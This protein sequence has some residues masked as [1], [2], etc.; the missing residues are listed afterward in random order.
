VYALALQPGPNWVA[1]RLSSDAGGDGS[2]AEA[3]FVASDG[4][5]VPVHRLSS[6]ARWF[7]MNVRYSC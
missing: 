6:T 7:G 5:L 2:S 1:L 3:R 4:V